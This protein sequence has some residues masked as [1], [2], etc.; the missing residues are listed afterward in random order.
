MAEPLAELC[1]QILVV[2]LGSTELSTSE[3]RALE[4]G[5]RG[6]VVLFKRNLVGGV[7]GPAELSRLTHSI[8]EAAPREQPP[9]VAIDQE[10]GRVVRIGPPALA[11]PPM[12]RIGD[13]DDV[14]LAT[15]LAEAQA[16]ELSA[17]GIT[18]SFAP[19]ADIHTRPEN[20]IIGDRAFAE[21]PEGVIRFARAWARGLCRGDVLSCLKH[22]PGHGDTTVDSHL[23]LPRVERAREELTRIELAPFRELARDSA[24]H[25]MMTAHVVY[26]ALDASP[27]TLSHGICTKLLREELGF[28]GVLFSD[29]LEMK[30]IQLPVGEAAVLAVRAGCDV[31]LVCSREDLV[32]EAHAALVREAESSPAFRIRCEE[33]RARSL[34]MR[35]R[36]SP[37]P[38]PEAELAAVFERSRAVASELASRLSLGGAS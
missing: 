5:E 6:G 17:L 27:A 13:L 20:P 22:F 18:I 1:G 34:A 32:E 3:R 21:T 19:V 15:R 10:G 4:R 35:R 12:R 26:P 38:V 24:V 16:R 33:A 9:L 37:R 7:A 29:D 23:E 2:G 8:R 11:L 28:E 25:S 14:E 30:A 36:L 31:L